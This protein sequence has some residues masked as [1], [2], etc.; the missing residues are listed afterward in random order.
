[1]GKHKQ[2]DPMEPMRRYERVVLGHLLRLDIKKLAR[3][4]QLG[5]G[6]TGNGRVSSGG[7]GWERAHVCVDD[8]TRLT[9]VDVLPDEL[10]ETAAAFLERAIEHFQKMGV[11]L[12]QIMTDNGSCYRLKIFR[13]TCE[14]FNT[15]HL[16]TRPYRPQINGKSE[17]FIQTLTRSWARRR[18]YRT[19]DERRGHMVLCAT[20]SESMVVWVKDRQ[21]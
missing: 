19:S 12:N 18:T 4:D 6:V 11:A 20:F 16:F 15:R 5:H 21:S 17:R 1:M 9:Y 13:K 7:A 14:R 10:G 8:H 2:F 3:F